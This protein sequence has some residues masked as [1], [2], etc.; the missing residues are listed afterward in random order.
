MSSVDVVVV[1]AGIAGLFAARALAAQGAS[2]AVVEARDRVGGRTWSEE[3][4]GVVFDRG[5]Q[6]ISPKQKRI[7]AL[8]R[9]LGCAT[10]PT[11]CKGKKVLD[12]GGKVS[13]YDGT[14]PNLSPVNLLVLQ[15]ALTRAETMRKRVPAGRPLDAR[16]AAA[17]D[18]TTLAAWQARNVPSK[19]VRDVFDVAVRVI[20]G[21]ESSELSLLYFLHYANAGEGLMNLVEIENGAQ[22]D[23]FVRGAQSVSRTM[24]EALGD[25]VILG[26]PVRRIAQDADGVTV[27]TDRGEHR[28]KY[29]V[30]AVPPNMAFRIDYTPSLP[31][32]RD[33][34]TQ[35]MAMGATSKHVAYYERPFW[36]DRGMS[37]EVASTGG[38]L[39]VVFDNSPS[40]GGRGALLGFAVGAGARALA[41][42]PAE[43]RKRTVLA[44]LVRFF[45]KD[46]AD[47]IA[48][49]EQDWGSEIWTRGCP[50]GTMSPGTMTHFGHALREPVGRIHW[51]GTETATEYCG[52]MEGAVQSGERVAKEIGARL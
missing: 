4:S 36:R 43:E 15:Y 27:H 13:A 22:Q 8:A 39:T 29:V 37:G 49:A 30:V 44:E 10:F 17:L 35:R 19:T 24:A 2:V 41:A 31:A 5:G 25:R 47:P 33:A 51:A 28:G 12:V 18:A 3:V 50:T 26:A 20:F 21:A 6:W 34:L 16:D 48:Y 42:R 46:A 52:F 40:S 23:R 14:I 38:P 11:W 9:E 1:G 45:G 32:A 7:T